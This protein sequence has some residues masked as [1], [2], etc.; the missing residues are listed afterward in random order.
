M[1][2]CRSV[3]TYRD[4]L[5]DKAVLKMAVTIA[6]KSNSV[7]IVCFLDWFV[8]LAF[9]G[10][11]LSPRAVFPCTYFTIC[12]SG[13][14][15]EIDSSQ[16]VCLDC[17]L[18]CFVKCSL[19]TVCVSQLGLNPSLETEMWPV[20]THSATRLLCLYAQFSMYSLLFTSSALTWQLD[21][22]TAHFTKYSY[23]PGN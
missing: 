1:I 14:L 23:L 16:Y 8:C 20:G 21:Y 5:I 19:V 6:T 2:I 4:V 11:S 15:F 9:S 22:C 10:E 13:E 18:V 12:V 3:T 17:L 7:W